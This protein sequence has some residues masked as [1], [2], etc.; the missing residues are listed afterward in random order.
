MLAIIIHIILSHLNHSFR[1]GQEGMESIV[2]DGW[3]PLC[4]RSLAPRALS[5]KQSADKP[6]PYYPSSK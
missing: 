6:L 4:S 3:L 1:A 5:F 2:R